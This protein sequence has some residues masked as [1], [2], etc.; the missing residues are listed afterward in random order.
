MEEV[1]NSDSN[2]M[3]GQHR[4]VQLWVWKLV[5][6]SG[7]KSEEKGGHSRS[8]I[9]EGEG[10]VVHGVDAHG[11]PLILAKQMLTLSYEKDCRD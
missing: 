5:Q 10:W 4:Y 2:D 7:N 3:S 6:Q 9:F 8:D 11:E 1:G